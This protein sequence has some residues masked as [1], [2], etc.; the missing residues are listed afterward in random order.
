MATQETAHPALIRH[1]AERLPEVDVE[2]YNLEIEDDEGFIGD[3]ASKAAFRAFIEAWRKPLRDVGQDPFGDEP[4]AALS[5]KALDAILNGGDSE[6]AGVVH[7]AIES[8]A[9]ELAFVARRFLKLKE[10]KGVERLVIGG[11]MRGSRVGE[12][13]IGRASV[14]L[15]A[16]KIKVDVEMIRNDP[17]EAGLLGAVHL[18]PAWIFKGHDAALA[19]DI[20]GTNIRAG[21]VALN[22]KREANLAKAKVEKFELWRHGDD[23]PSRDDVVESLVRMLKRLIARAKDD[24]LHL[25]PFIGIGCPGK[26][27]AD[28]SIEKKRRAEPARQLGEQPLQPAGQHL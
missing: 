8:F 26:I 14:I 7:S 24:G 28:G 4:S 22:L 9:Q 17:D 3:R 12:L 21:L 15:K 6:A 11:G 18:A 16:D 20:G 10:W 13:A 25:A 19:V 1:G 23:K 2:A 5:K 27:D